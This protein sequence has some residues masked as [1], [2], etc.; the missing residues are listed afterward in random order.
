MSRMV[1]AMPASGRF[2]DGAVATGRRVRPHP[3]HRVA[4]LDH[5]L[6][7]GCSLGV[8]AARTVGQRHHPA[9]GRGRERSARRCG[10]VRSAATWS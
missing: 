2:R 6:E 10:R 3:P 4:V 9:V 5:R 7:Q 1:A 8:V